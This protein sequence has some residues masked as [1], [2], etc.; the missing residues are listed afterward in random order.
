MAHENLGTTIPLDK[1]G[2]KEKK[3]CCVIHQGNLINLLNVL[4]APN[5]K[6]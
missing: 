3:S 6:K 1:A 5:G 2:G 4:V